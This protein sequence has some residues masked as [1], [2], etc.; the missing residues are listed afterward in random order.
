M[1]ANPSMH[2]VAKLGNKQV[3]PGPLSPSRATMTT[4]AFLKL[5]KEIIG[6]LLLALT[7]FFLKV[8]RQG[9]KIHKAMKQ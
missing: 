1:T 3:N 5:P 8:L 2:H 7:F 4:N 6:S 9:K